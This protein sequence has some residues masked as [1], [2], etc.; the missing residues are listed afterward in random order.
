MSPANQTVSW[1]GWE[2][3]R[4][5]GAGSFGT[6]YEIRREMFGRQESA[7]LKVIS[8]PSDDR[9]IADLR[10]E[11][12]ADDQLTEHF[13]SCLEDIAREYALMMEMKGHTNVV[14]CDDVRYV[15]HADGIGWDALIKM[16]LLIPLNQV[17]SVEYDES[18]VLRLGMDLCSALMLCER[19]K[20]LHRD[21]KP[22]NIFVSRD[23]DF[24]LGDFGVAKVAEKTSRGTKIGS[25]QFM[26]PEVYKNQP[27]G[28]SADLYSLGLVLYWAMNER[29]T[30]FLPP[31]PQIPR[32]SEEEDARQRRFSGEKIPDPRNGSSR[33]KQ[34]V[35]K[36]C[37]YDPRDRYESPEVMLQALRMVAA[38]NP[39]VS[40]KPI[41]E[42]SKVAPEPAGDRTVG[43]F[44]RDI[45]P[46][47]VQ[48][49]TPE[50]DP[51]PP[52]PKPR[53]IPVKPP[54]PK[55][56]PEKKPEGMSYGMKIACWILG[57]VV[58]FALVI[59]IY[60][61]TR[62]GWYN[63]DGK[64]YYYESGTAAKGFYTIDGKL[65]HFDW[66]GALSTD[67]FTVLGK[68]YYCPEGGGIVTGWQTIDGERYYFFED[69]V[70]ATNWQTIGGNTYYFGNRGVMVTGSQ[71]IDDVVYEFRSNGVLDLERGGNG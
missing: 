71:I 70:M 18:L 47:P 29:R 8:I 14:S 54:E 69:G 45:R 41:E 55:P 50:F 63:R 25:F 30:P 4:T 6:V 12:Y 39:A 42:K 2:V 16:E 40:R 27:Y 34:I 67:W 62:T 24:K 17:I 10:R 46:A 68:K 1:P 13:R 64:T 48:E 35:L 53:T 43:V 19:R 32:P 7:A 26:S 58:V 23:G 49:P 57:I 15:Q 52:K 56:Q 36:A 59:P 22:Q 9:E 5:V 61:G 65:Y 20:V 37:A 60:F 66:T 51:E 11:G 33:L 3:V 21:I 28:S 38:E 44:H 31:Q